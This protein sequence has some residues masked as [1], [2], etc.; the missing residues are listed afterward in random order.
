MLRVA[1]KFLLELRQHLDELGELAAL[2]LVLDKHKRLVGGLHG[3]ELVVVVL[4]GTEHEVEFVLQLQFLPICLSIAVKR[5]F[6][7]I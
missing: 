6:R 3:V 1:R 7:Q 2:F 4:D 5:I